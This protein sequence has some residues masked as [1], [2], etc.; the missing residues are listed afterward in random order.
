MSYS[1]VPCTD[2]AC[3]DEFVRT[4]PQGSIFCHSKL[5]EALG[6]PFD[7]WFVCDQSGPPLLAVPVQRRDGGPRFVPYDSYTTYRF[8]IYQGPMLAAHVAAGA[9]HDAV[10]QRLEL[11]EFMLSQLSER[12]PRLAWVLHPALQDVRAFTWFNYHHEAGGRFVVSPRYTGIIDLTLQHHDAYFQSVR[13]LRRREFKA[14]AQAGIICEPSTDIDL[15]DRLE[16]MV[17]ERQALERTDDDRASRRALTESAL[18]HGYGRMWVAR[19]PSGEVA[20]AY[21]FLV[22]ERAGYHLF[23]GNHPDLRKSGATTY[24]MF[25]A[26]EQL[27][28]EG[29]QWMDVIGLNSPRR[30]DFK[31]SFNAVPTLN[32]LVTWS[33]PQS[34]I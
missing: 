27:R 11:L 19:L 26:L 12:Y 10:P 8:A 18:R 28:R 4:S 15:L 2:M 5:L 9:T 31:T 20:T 7:C 17:F 21:L 14:A 29:K 23:A 25:Y 33:R 1:L 22:D 13:R 6:E 30:G 32:F 16:D 3:W 24:L 34:T